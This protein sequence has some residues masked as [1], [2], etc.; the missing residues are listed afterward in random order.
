MDDAPFL[1]YKLSADLL[2]IGE[3]VKRGAFRPTAT[4]I[5]FS[6]IVGALWRT[7]AGDYADW[8]A[9]GVIE[10]HGGPETLLSAP[11]DRMT[12]VARLPLVTEVLTDVRASVFV[13]RTR[14]SQSL[15][16]EFELALGA[17]RS[18]GLGRCRL[19]RAGPL[20]EHPRCA[21]ELATRIPERRL[22]DFAIEPVAPLYCYL[23]EPG[24]DPRS[25]TAGR[26][27]RALREGSRVRAPDFLL[28]HRHDR[29]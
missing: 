23:W 1:R 28:A 5:P 9:A 7:F 13:K 10:Q 17:L 22:A 16:E 25:V 6:T 29:G 24:P 27:V 26:Y 12:S 20:G 4:T 19:H 15:P 18:K 14:A 8:I 11:V 3:R 21:G 2:C